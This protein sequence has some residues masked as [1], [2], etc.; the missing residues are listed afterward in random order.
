MAEFILVG[1]VTIL[2]I[3]VGVEV[4]LG[5]EKFYHLVAGNVFGDSNDEVA[6]HHKGL[7]I[8]YICFG[9]F[10]LSALWWGPKLQESLN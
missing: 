6:K 10:V 3:F 7:G 5:H 4:Y 8:F 1:L 9:L 2:F